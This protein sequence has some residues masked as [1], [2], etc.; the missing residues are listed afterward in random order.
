M[1]ARLCDAVR[2]VF[3]RRR[4]FFG[5]QS[6]GADIVAGVRQLADRCPETTCIIEQTKQS[7]H[8]QRPGLYHAPI[9]R[10][11]DPL[12]KNND[13]AAVLSSGVGDVVDIALYKYCYVDITDAT[14]IWELF[15]QYCRNMLNLQER[16]PAVSFIHVTVPLTS[17]QTG[18]RAW[19]KKLIGRPIDG[20][21]DNIR[22]HGFNELMRS[23][24][25][26]RE[27]FFD[28]AALGATRADGSRSC[29]H[30]RGA[31][32]PALA[33]ELTPDGGHLNERGREM[34]AGALLRLLASLDSP[35]TAA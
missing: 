7:A 25:E 17:V 29:F 14:N 21:V 13:F 12:A 10:N 9:G 35:E 28:L 16:F 22:R 31:R 11:R 19:V 18:P 30:H 15:S 2:Q 27:P 34:V 24:F 23:T 4:I 5:H 32:Y 20:M 33:P 1:S 26:K 8:M 6:V 3:G